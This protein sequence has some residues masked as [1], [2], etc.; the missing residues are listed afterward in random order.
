MTVDWL[1]YMHCNFA[2]IFMRQEVVVSLRGEPGTLFLATQ[3]LATL[4]LATLFLATW[5]YTC[6]MVH[7][8]NI[9]STSSL[10]SP[11][12]YLFNPELQKHN[13]KSNI[14]QLLTSL[15]IDELDQRMIHLV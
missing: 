15:G 1:L 9:P 6:H 8:S 10:P 12:S 11:S 2:T 13:M 3:F 14:V 5:S 7:N 4:F